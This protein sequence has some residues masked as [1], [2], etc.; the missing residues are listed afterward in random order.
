M[1]KRRIFEWSKEM[2]KL[3]DG[4][5]RASRPTPI[6]VGRFSTKVDGGASHARRY[7][8]INYEL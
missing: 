8:E 1:T 2:L 6:S 7:A 5:T 4:T 3:I